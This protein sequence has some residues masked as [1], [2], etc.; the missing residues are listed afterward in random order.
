MPRLGHCFSIG[1]AISVGTVWTIVSRE[2]TV[3]AGRIRQ[4]DRSM[5][6]TD[7]QK[8]SSELSNDQFSNPS[9]G[10]VDSADFL[11]TRIR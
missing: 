8:I 5:Q 9:C 2:E 11:F 10:L 3:L 6:Y 7:C 1:V 4:D